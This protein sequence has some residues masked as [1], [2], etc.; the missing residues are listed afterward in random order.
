MKGMNSTAQVDS[1]VH[2][3]WKTHSGNCRVEILMICYYDILTNICF[4]SIRKIYR[5][6]IH[7]TYSYIIQA[8]KN[9]S[10]FPPS[11]GRLEKANLCLS[12]FSDPKEVG[13]KS[14][15]NPKS[16]DLKV[17]AH[18]LSFESIWMFWGLFFFETTRHLWPVKKIRGNWRELRCCF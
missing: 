12:V 14:P 18:S 10:L 16:P 13:K 17:P 1:N 2:F 9:N 3:C 5:L 7:D 8:I 11:T 15:E 4:H 6:Y